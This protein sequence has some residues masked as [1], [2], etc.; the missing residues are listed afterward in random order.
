MVGQLNNT[1]KNDVNL[2]IAYCLVK[3]IYTQSWSWQARDM[4]VEF[5]FDQAF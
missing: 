4:C 1:L 5:E 2:T 3:T